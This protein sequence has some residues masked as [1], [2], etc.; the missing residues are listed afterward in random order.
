MLLENFNFTARIVNLWICFCQLEVNFGDFTGY[1][2]LL[3]VIGERHYSRS[4][5]RKRV[6][7]D[8]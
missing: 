1:S 4:G 2:I 3:Y 6:T 8:D 7:E 5:F